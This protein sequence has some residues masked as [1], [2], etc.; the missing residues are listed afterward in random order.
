MAADLPEEVKRRPTLTINIPNILTVL[1]I[2]ITPLCCHLSHPEDARACAAGLH[3]RRCKRWPGRADRAAAQP[4]QR[5]R[6][7]PSARFADKLLLTAA[8]ISLGIL[9]ADPRLETLPWW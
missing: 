2:L 6:C 3:L 4:A 9:K 8:Y 1:R 5:T 7:T